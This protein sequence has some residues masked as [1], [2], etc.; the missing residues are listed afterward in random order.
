MER[1]ARQVQETQRLLA[2]P[3][4]DWKDCSTAIEELATAVE[5]LRSAESYRDAVRLLLNVSVGIGA[6]LASI[7]SKLVKDVCEHLLRIVKVTGG[8]FQELA[9]VLMPQIVSTAK[10]SSAAIRQP[11]AKLL[12][13]LSET[14]RYDVGLVRKIFLQLTQ[15]KVRVLL[16]EQ[17]RIILVYWSDDEL[18]P[19]RAD[20]LEMVRRGLEDQNTGVRTAAREVLTRISSRWRERVDELMD[21][22]SNHAKMLIITEHRDSPLAEAIVER[23]PELANKSEM[24]SRSRSSPMK[25]RTSFR[26]SPRHKKS[27]QNIEIHVS[28]TPPPKQRD[29]QDA[30]MQ[31]T[32]SSELDTVITESVSAA[33]TNI[34][35]DL[36]D[37]EQE[38]IPEAFDGSQMHGCRA[39]SVKREIQQ[40]SQLE[41]TQIATGETAISSRT[42]V[43]QTTSVP[44][45]DEVLPHPGVAKLKESKIPSPSNRSPSFLNKK[46]FESTT[47]TSSSPEL[48][49]SLLPRPGSFTLK[50][51]GSSGPSTPV[52]AAN[53]E[54]GNI[55]QKS[56][57]ASDEYFSKPIPSSC[58]TPTPTP[59]STDNVTLRPR[60]RAFF[61]Q[62]HEEES[63]LQAFSPAQTSFEVEESTQALQVEPTLEGVCSSPVIQE[64]SPHLRE[65]QYA[66][67]T[68]DDVDD[69]SH[70]TEGSDQVESDSEWNRH[71][72][73][74]SESRSGDGG[75]SVHGDTDEPEY[76]GDDDADA[77]SEELGLDEGT[78]HKS[79]FEDEIGNRLS[80]DET[81]AASDAE[82]EPMLPN[83]PQD[84]DVEWK[85]Y[86][87]SSPKEQFSV[88]DDVKEEAQEE[89]TPAK[90]TLEALLGVRDEMA[91]LRAATKNEEHSYELS[92]KERDT[93]V[94][95]AFDPSD[96][97]EQ[98]HQ[99]MLAKHDEEPWDKPG[100]PYLARLQNAERFARS[101]LLAPPTDADPEQSIESNILDRLTPLQTV[102]QTRPEAATFDVDHDSSSEHD[103][104]DLEAHSLSPPRVLEPISTRSC[105]EDQ[106]DFVQEFRPAENRSPR[107]E[108]N[109]PSPQD[110]AQPQ[111]T[112]FVR[113]ELEH[114]E[115]FDAAEKLFAAKETPPHHGCYD[116]P[117][118][119]E[120]KLY[121][122][123]EPYQERLPPTQM[124]AILNPIMSPTPNVATEDLIINA[125]E[126]K[127]E[128]IPSPELQD[129]SATPQPDLKHYQQEA[130]FAKR[131]STPPATETTP[132][133]SPLN[134]ESVARP[135]STLPTRVPERNAPPATLDW[136]R[137]I[138]IW[139]IVFIAAMFCTAGVLRAAKTMR[140]SYEYHQALK[141]R[142][143]MFEASITESHEKVLKLEEDYAIWS[144][145]VRKL[146]DDDE[147]S[148]LR[149]LQ[150]IQIEVQKWQQDMKADLVQFRQALS[151]DSID[152]AFADLRA[153]NTKQI[154]Q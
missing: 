32:A 92:L 140:E 28:A 80:D 84:L 137:S 136:A 21:I 56:L 33:E 138:G 130:N 104:L 36:D 9:N 97:A 83:S 143:D 16:L 42:T 144:E 35:D 148:A 18:T 81:K 153:N 13:K 45:F 62:E 114:A 1:L 51:Q 72:L 103:Y 101:P 79:D 52:A 19:W 6:Q 26:K 133:V 93:P 15:D 120:P 25:L 127:A 43:A 74:D 154:E 88:R 85:K 30:A 59:P 49:P 14:V 8:D 55:E 150:A 69:L 106:F 131:D 128:E 68:S 44:S 116:R 12:C 67:Y 107:A 66:G 105:K 90:D 87:E 89:A 86:A 27:E 145:Y 91:R 98:S 132:V 41:S 146:A 61:N 110:I 7:R 124:G 112:Y 94:S 37:D 152:A 129:T 151:V 76:S 78:R 100:K 147:S 71:R 123:S 149:Q 60:R 95:C 47:R 5:S 96:T 4:T 99:Q 40:V 125:A 29:Q 34:F 113:E 17:L 20:M 48:R 119:P 22:P 126:E 73:D 77:D 46:H 141:T 50:S 109:V 64:E 23:N 58:A 139:V 38:N 2:D 135:V 39:T 65:N 10:S 57:S 117:Q 53:V 75:E 115:R 11:G 134:P 118:S 111:E 24:F 63:S 121:M 108:S 142:I 82:N 102:G 70:L 122:H 3:T 31:E 54:E